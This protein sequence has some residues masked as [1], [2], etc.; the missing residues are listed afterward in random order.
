MRNII[1]YILI[2]TILVIIFIILNFYK[3]NKFIFEDIMIFG[4]WSDN[5]VKNQYEINSQSEIQIDVFQ[6]INNKFNKK[7]APGSKGN[8][9]IKF[10]R[11]IDTKYSIKINEKTVKPRN[12]IFTL[13]NKQYNSIEDME[14]IINEKFMN[15]DEITI[16]WEWKYY[17]N[18]IEDI[19]DTRDGE[20]AQKYIFEIIAV[21]E[22]GEGAEI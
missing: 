12:L 13:E 10:K 8:F 11:S 16:N 18:E 21:V 15:A 2:L 5:G 19:S 17:I 3:S 22:E 4:L 6:T 20:I 14:E 7:I 9:R 1:K